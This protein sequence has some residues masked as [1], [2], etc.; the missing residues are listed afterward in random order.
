MNAAAVSAIIS[1]V[2]GSLV[3]IAGLWLSRRSSREANRTQKR[4]TD[5]QTLSSTVDALN[6]EVDR[7]QGALTAAN[8]KADRL[9]FELDA[10]QYNV[11]V[12][13]NH[14]RRYIPERAFPELREM[15]RVR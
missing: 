7:L 13:S 10:A 6:D 15:N 5:L 14:V 1:L 8:A 3:T 12:L 9:L 4:L 11:L 2:V